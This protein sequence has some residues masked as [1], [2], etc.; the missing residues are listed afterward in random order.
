MQVFPDSTDEG[1]E[2]KPRR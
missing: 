2:R 1:R